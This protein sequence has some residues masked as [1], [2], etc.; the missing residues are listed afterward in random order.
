MRKS[1]I[2]AFALAAGLLS[3]CSSD[4]TISA[5][6][7]NLA[8]EG[9]NGLVPVEIG[10][11]NKMVVSTR[12]TGT[13]GTVDTDGGDDAN[14]YKNQWQGQSV[15]VYMFNKV[16]SSN[17]KLSL[18]YFN[19]YDTDFSGVIYENTEMVTPNTDTLNAGTANATL[20]TRADHAVKY[21]PPT[22]NYEFWGYRIDD[23]E[24]DLTVC[25]DSKPVPLDA[26]GNIIATAETDTAAFKIDF[27]IDGTQ[28][29]MTAKAD[30][31]EADIAV[32]GTGKTSNYFSAYSAR[33][34]IQPY[35]KFQHELARLTFKIKDGNVASEEDEADNSSSMKVVDIAVESPSEA[36]MVVAYTDFELRENPLSFKTSEDTNEL[37][38]STFNLKK[39]DESATGQ[40]NALVALTIDPEDLETT[41]D[42]D[43]AS[44]ENVAKYIA[45]PDKGAEAASIGEAI[46]I[47]PGLAEYPVIITLCERKMITEAYNDG[48]VYKDVIYRTPGV[49]KLPT[50]SQS[51]VFEKGTSYEVV[52]TVYG[53]QK[54]EINTTLTPWVDGGSTDVNPEED[55]LEVDE[56]PDSGE[57]ST[58]DTDIED[59]EGGGNPA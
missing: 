39:R 44:S 59:G 12:G 42:E 47:A 41:G 20:A 2:F 1:F 45:L 49:I 28:D 53:L 25:P 46:M 56:T 55:A 7:S 11:S 9:D 10:V 26:E 5:D 31:G 19:S 50:T 58:G 33:K 8:N 15:N 29:V 40:N 52:I 14:L 13:V 30:I 32:L 34:G 17:P 38:T 35:L 18:A 16:T 57:E 4:D 23:A 27:T 3:S 37:I 51:T 43:L 54:I 22:G 24:I 36:S 21:Y 48:H 6:G